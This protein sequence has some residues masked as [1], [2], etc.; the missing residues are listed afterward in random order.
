MAGA[1]PAAAQVRVSPTG[2]NVNS[3]GATT[4][5]LTFGPLNGYAPREAMWCG[6]LLPAAGVGSRCDP[7]TIYGLLPARY[8]QSRVGSNN[9]YTDVM[10]LPES[11]ARRAYQAAAAGNSAEF[12]YVRHFTKTGA[13][14]VFV[15][16]T[17]RLSGGGASV[18]LS[19]VDVNL[20]FDVETPVLQVAAGAKLPAV[21]AQIVYTGSGR[22][23]G[24]WEVVLP[25]QELPTARDLLTEATLSPDQRGTQHRFAEI[26]RFNVF[27]DPTGRYTL[28]GPDPGKFPTG[29]EGSYLVLLRVETSDDKEADTDLAALGVGAGVV[30]AGGVAGFPMPTLRYIV[31][32]GGSELSPAARSSIDIVGPAD[33]IAMAATDVLDLEW[34]GVPQT[35]FY[36]IDVES[37]GAIVHQAFVSPVEHVYRLPPFVAGK[38]TAGALR[39]RVVSVDVAGRDGPSSPWRNVVLARRP[40]A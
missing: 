3:Q 6:T 32:G 14:D 13:P 8:D 5:L 33:G 22:L 7:T 20:A 10:S 36:R 26:D 29:V 21:S 39:W 15:A 12:F 37:G 11:V 18:P 19:L 30:H 28:S 23:Q 31:G 25:G 2:I 34:R 40:S 1:R 38:V 4:A 24:R 27:L 17:C 9:A 35:A 16:V